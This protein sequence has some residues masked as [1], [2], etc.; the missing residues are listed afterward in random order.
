MQFVIANTFQ[1]SLAKLQAAEQTAAKLAAMEMQMNP[2]HPSLKM[3]RL[4]KVR[5]K[6]FWSA[7]ANDDVRLIVHRTEN[8]CLLCY[9][10]HH[11]AAYAWAERRKLS[12]HPATGAAQMVVLKETVQEVVVRN[13]VEETSIKPAETLPLL[14]STSD[15][16]LLLYGVP[17]E[18]I[19]LVRS[20]QEDNVLDIASL[21]PEEAAQALLALATGERP[22]PGPMA[23]LPSAAPVSA[24]TLER[25]A[26]EHPD[27]KRR[28]RVIKDREELERALDAPWDKWAV[29][30][31]PAQRA[32]VER[33]FSGPARVTGSAGT[34][35]TVVA[36][37]RAVYLAESHP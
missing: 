29:F 31:H 11:D 4:D 18:Q 7:R 20:A 23:A 8:S 16:E 32:L 19:P 26:F 13:Y 2:A 35:K 36:L 14:A 34:G 21:L 15:V 12:V 28:F 24:E 27:S 6:N 22:V 3:H 10:G 25:F 17:E 5:D 30:L 1:E 33:H 37:H 9:T